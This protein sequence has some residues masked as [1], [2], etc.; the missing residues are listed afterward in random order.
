MK[1]N[2]TIVRERRR[3]GG[4]HLGWMGRSL[5]ALSRWHLNWDLRDGMEPACEKRGKGKGQERWMSWACAG[6][7]R[8]ALWPE[9]NEL[10]KHCTKWGW[11]RSKDQSWQG[12]VDVFLSAKGGHLRVSSREVMWA[13]VFLKVM[14]AMMNW[15]EE[16][17]RVVLF[18]RVKW[19]GREVSRLPIHL[20]HTTSN[21]GWYSLWDLLYDTA[22][23]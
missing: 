5:W 15:R 22:C 4:F 9:Q 17:R 3:P 14:N 6:N 23:N 10:G 2:E 18:L 8:R 19:D 13:D 20:P 7:Q 11:R 12:V 16:K 21:C 1:N